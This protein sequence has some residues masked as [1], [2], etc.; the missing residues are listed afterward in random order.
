MALSCQHYPR[1][2]GSWRDALRAA[3]SSPQ[4]YGA[5]G[6]LVGYLMR[7]FRKTWFVNLYGSLQINATA[8]EID[9]VVQGA[10]TGCR[11]TTSGRR[12]SASS[13]RRCS[14][15]GSAGGPAFEA[16][17][18]PHALAPACGARQ[19]AADGRRARGGVTRW[20]ID[21]D[22]RLLRA[23]AATA[24]IEPR[25]ASPARNGAG[26]AA[27]AARRRAVLHRRRRSS[28]R[29]ADAVGRHQRAAGAVVVRL[30]RPRRRCPTTCRG[31]ATCRSFLSE[32]R[33]VAQF[34]TLRDGT[35][36]RRRS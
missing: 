8:D 33:R 1:P 20:L 31:T 14:V 4:L 28:R 35:R 15:R 17:G 10:S 2:T 34:T 22:G 12:R 30:R 18:Q 19:P 21:G 26:R 32:Q 27:G 13:R 25:I 36:P 9:A 24:T 16:D 3:R 6:W 7:M 23:G 29:D 11:W 5:G